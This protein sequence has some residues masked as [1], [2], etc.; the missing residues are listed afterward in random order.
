MGEMKTDEQ[1][2]VMDEKEKT[3]RVEREGHREVHELPFL[4]LS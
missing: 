3:V 4:T 2:K 1:N